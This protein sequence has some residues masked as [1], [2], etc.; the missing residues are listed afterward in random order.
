MCSNVWTDPSANRKPFV[1]LMEAKLGKLH[2][3]R[4]LRN[5]VLNRIYP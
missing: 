5:V 3:E 2:Q 1:F 4:I